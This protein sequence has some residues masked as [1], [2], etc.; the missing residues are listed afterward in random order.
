M[1]TKIKLNISA[2]TD[3][4]DLP[5]KG[6]R[7]LYTR[8]SDAQNRQTCL[9]CWCSA[10]NPDKMLCTRQ[11]QFSLS[12]SQDYSSRGSSGKAQLSL[13]FA[14]AT[15]SW[16]HLSWGAVDCVVSEPETFWTRT[17]LLHLSVLIR[18]WTLA[19]I[20]SLSQ[21]YPSR[22]SSGKSQLSLMFALA[23][24]SWKHLSWQGNGLCSIWTSDFLNLHFTLR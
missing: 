12:L 19:K 21:G 2:W 8:S 16:R 18:C 10:V 23:T 9:S 3:P 11:N 5:G 1:D 4:R 6:G 13:M 17:L 7:S 22:G 15:I 24:I 14:L 20:N